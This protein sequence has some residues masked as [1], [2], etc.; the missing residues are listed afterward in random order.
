MAAQD[1]G[2]LIGW[3]R[4]G[5][6]DLP[7]RGPI[8]RDPYSVVVSEVM[9]QQTQVQR[10][11]A[12]YP[13]FLRRFPSIAALAA[14]DV[15]EVVHA[16]AGLGYYRRARLLHQAARAIVARGAWPTTARELA[17]L[18][19]FGAYTAAAVA[20]LAF[21][22]DEPPVD[23]N[24]ARVTARVLALALPLGSPAL[25]RAGRAF[26]RDLHVGAPDP[27]L[28]EALMEL[29]ATVCTPTSPRCDECPLLPRCAAAAA[30][31]AEAFPLPRTHRRRERQRWAA[32]WLE[33]PDR[34]VLLRRVD[35]G[36]LLAGLWLPPFAVLA[37]REDPEAAARALARDAAWPV[38]L[39]PVAAVRHTITH[40]DI[41]VLPFVGSV[42]AARVGE[43]RA[44]WRWHDPDHPSVP[45]S[46]LL[47]KLA[48]ACG[49]RRA[50]S[51]HR[52]N[53]EE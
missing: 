49:R 33:R 4:R 29:G 25:L 51:P 42:A 13:A 43:D 14:A 41:Q 50:G 32:V 23:G 34:T 28:F 3:F 52:A 48:A 19:G 35:E 11:A 20:A 2:T 37:D 46:T 8:P 24:V 1:A 36:P 30:G 53:G 39:A 6:R 26:A 27:E 10:A 17:M 12:A 22:G 40:R 5:R 18:P 21:G 7:W 9:A 47:A 16:F 31:A 44:G 45:S 38:P 15:D